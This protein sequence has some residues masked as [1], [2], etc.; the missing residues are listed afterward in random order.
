MRSD[1]HK[2]FTLFTS[3]RSQRRSLALPAMN[4]WQGA[5]DALDKALR[6]RDFDA[7]T[8]DQQLEVAEIKVLLSVGQ[9]LS[10]I[11]HDGINP[12]FTPGE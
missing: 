1:T 7:L 2:A 8:L 6:S 5:H 10:G 11:H 4:L 3:P 12:Q 9:E